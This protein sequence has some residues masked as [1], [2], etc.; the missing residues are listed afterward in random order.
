MSYQCCFRLVL[1]ATT[2]ICGRAVANCTDYADR[3]YTT[4]GVRTPD[5][6]SCVDIAGEHAFVG[7]IDGLRVIDLSDPAHPAIVGELGSSGWYTQA[8]AASGTIVYLSYSLGLLVVDVAD[9]TS[10]E[11]IG[12]LTGSVPTDL[13]AAD[14]IAYLAGYSPPPQGTL[15]V[16]DAADPTSPQIIGSV[17]TPGRCVAVAASGDLACVAD[18][19]AGLQI[20]DVSDP[21]APWIIATV[22]MNAWGVYLDGATAYVALLNDG[23]ALVDL[24]DPEVPEV[25]GTL[26]LPGQARDVAVSGDRAY[27]AAT[28]Q[29]LQVVDVSVPQSPVLV[30]S[31]PTI[32]VAMGVAA[33]G[34]LACV[35]ASGAGLRVI[36]ASDPPP[37]P[38]YLPLT[39]SA[40]AID[41]AVQDGATFAYVGFTDNGIDAGLDV[42]DFSILGQ[43]RLRGTASTMLYV[44][45]SDVTVDWPYAYLGI[46]SDGLPALRVVDVSDPDNPTFISGWVPFSFYWDVVCG[47]D[48]AGGFVY[49]AVGDLGLSVVDVSNP[50]DP[51]VVGD[52]P[53]HANAI[54]VEGRYAYVLSS[55]QLQVV[56]VLHPASPVLVATLGISGGA[57]LVLDRGIA[58]VTVW[59][60]GGLRCVDV[61][62]PL[63][64]EVVGTLSGIPLGSRLA[65]HGDFLYITTLHD[66]VQ[67]VDIGDPEAPVLVGNANLVQNP[68]DVS[69][70][71]DLVLVGDDTGLRVFPTQCVL[72]GAEDRE[73]RTRG[74]V[75]GLAPNPTRSGTRVEFALAEGA[76]VRLRIFDVEGRPVR[77]LYDGRLP[78]GEHGL[79]WDG[80][81]N[82]GRPAP[83][84]VYWMRLEVGGRTAGAR[85]V[86][87]R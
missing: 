9:P 10:P 35:A 11:P 72:S 42:V 54:D 24:S 56:D 23:I 28:V 64:P 65:V 75:L 37:E 49:G 12:S 13:A 81:T 43:P 47:L 34:T 16:V 79:S 38:P 4:A 57:S 2:V 25:L 15:R 27:V 31:I 33:E 32:D 3:L 21:A 80:T 20:I 51:V 8:V 74:R 39:G 5:S 67:V 7:D 17:D 69:V 44:S 63:A 6:A 41:T 61:T 55:S 66:G 40:R 78:A 60:T 59:P 86:V 48:Y 19:E 84:G 62:N 22:P 36:D 14:S 68:D 73:D 52:L 85:L 87:V 82:A 71:D 26:A 58:Y 29:G 50:R 70:V 46:S 45:V 76:L 30:R 18:G 83:A 77:R 53:M 1:F